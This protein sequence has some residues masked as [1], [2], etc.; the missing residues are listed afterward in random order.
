MRHA[1]SRAGHGLKILAQLHL[2]GT[3]APNGTETPV[4]DGRI[5]KRKL[6]ENFVTPLDTGLDGRPLDEVSTRRRIM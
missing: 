5:K 2:Y 1:R 6:F 3:R 4:G